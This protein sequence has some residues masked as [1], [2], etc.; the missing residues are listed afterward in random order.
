MELSELGKNPIS[1]DKPGGE[2]VRFE[3]EYEALENEIQKLSSPTSSEGIDWGKVLTLSQDILG[4]K[5][6]NLLVACYMCV[7]LLN[8][9]GLQGFADG[10]HVLREML[11]NFW[12]TM[13]PPKKRMRGRINAIEW[14]VEKTDAKIEG[15]NTEKW[16]QEKYDR[17]VKDLN[18]IDAFLGDNT[19]DAP[20]LRSLNDRLSSLVEV[21]VPPP[22]PP[23]DEPAGQPSVETPSE[24]TGSKPPEAAVEQAAPAPPPPPAAPVQPQ[25]AD[26]G[27]DA[28][29]LVKQGLDTLGKAAS[30]LIKKDT[31]SAVPFRLNRIVA[32]LSVE[33]LPPATDGK[34]LI[35]PPDEQVVSSLHSLYQTQNWRDLLQAAESRVRQYLFWIDLSRYTAEALE[36][37]RYN[38]I[39]ETVCSETVSYVN[40]LTG[41]E[42]LGFADG[43]PF[44]DAETKEW[45]RE[46]AQQQGGADVSTGSG[47][48]KVEQ[49]VEQELAEAQKMIKENKLPAALNNFREKLN[50]ASSSRERFIWEIGLC[51]LL[52]RAKLP[53]LVIPYTHK[54]LEM[55]DTYKIEQWEPA[56]AVEGLTVVLSGLKLQEEKKD[57]ELIRSIVNRVAAIN[58]ARVLDFL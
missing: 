7:S 38:D 4:G 34:T 41:I 14:W 58:P 11:E 33:N 42:K 36:Q 29:K 30:Q 49:F 50:Q 47:G 25:E 5:S 2:D 10:V 21:D 24:E 22:E 48:S 19:E 12:D 28:G 45:L 13:F 56:L 1:S 8:A 37:L 3:P 39:S 26:M 9:K 53:Q 51:R 23:A 20:I 32:W 54:I 15:L 44:A 46:L 16:P 40:R 31:V 57:E 52:L 6:K 55:L 35:P 18:A 43:T 27:E 17:F